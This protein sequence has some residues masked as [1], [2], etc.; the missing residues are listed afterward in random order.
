MDTENQSLIAFD[1]AGG[2]IGPSAQAVFQQPAIAILGAG[3][4]GCKGWSET[5]AE[6]EQCVEP[7]DVIFQQ[8]QAALGQ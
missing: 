1:F 3:S 7:L 2:L 8:G 4:R 6:T 5:V